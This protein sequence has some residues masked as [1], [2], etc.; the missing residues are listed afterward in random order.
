[1]HIILNQL[2]LYCSLLLCTV[3]MGCSDMSDAERAKMRAEIQSQLDAQY[4]DM[5][6]TVLGASRSIDA[7]GNIYWD[8]YIFHV[9]DK[10]GLVFSH[11]WYD[12]GKRIAPRLRETHAKAS[13]KR[14]IREYLSAA[15]PS[16]LK[17]DVHMGV[18]ERD[19]HIFCTK[20]LTAGNKDAVI[21]A[22]RAT[23]DQAD[24]ALRMGGYVVQVLF[25]RQGSGAT[26]PPP[27]GY[28]GYLGVV[29]FSGQVTPCF[30]LAGKYAEDVLL[31]A[32]KAKAREIADR[33]GWSVST[34]ATFFQINQKDFSE[35]FAGIDLTRKDSPESMCLNMIFDTG[36]LEL[37]EHAIVSIPHA[38]SESRQSRYAAWRELIPSRFRCPEQVGRPKVQT[39]YCW[40]WEV[41]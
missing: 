25:A 27:Y 31:P 21:D 19:I 7:G 11:F 29:L 6:L 26:G 38:A 34:V 4:P 2:L 3:C 9:K 8:R 24:A 18:N 36:R 30:Q 16:D 5:G 20:E 12:K 35:I 28:D 15:L 23:L 1:M 22:L 40:W 33:E 37:K 41:R 17:A 32:V 14:D 39:R 13:R 10:T